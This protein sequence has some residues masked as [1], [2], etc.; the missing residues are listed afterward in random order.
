MFIKVHL[1]PVPLVECFGHHTSSG[2]PPVI[3]PP[4][5]LSSPLP[6]RGPHLFHVFLCVISYLVLVQLIDRVRAQTR[7]VA[8][9][10]I[11]LPDGEALSGVFQAFAEEVWFLN[12]LDHPNII[13]LY[14]FVVGRHSTS[15]SSSSIILLIS[16]VRL[17][18]EILHFLPVQQIYNHPRL[19]LPPPSGSKHLWS[20]GTTVSFIT[21][22][23]TSNKEFFFINWFLESKILGI[24][25][26]IMYIGDLYS[27]YNNP[28]N[29]MGWPDRL[30]IA[31]DIARY[32]FLSHPLSPKPPWCSPAATSTAGISNLPLLP[33]LCLE[34]ARTVVL[35]FALLIFLL[36]QS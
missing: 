1:P 22:A 6:S 23:K 34:S 29:V 28:A 33:S 30:E 36:L 27:Y 5:R 32:T 7:I 12:M 21:I 25:A 24:A 26:E 15:T 11:R 17:S 16:V 4:P 35:A 19:F 13:H 10:D 20:F 14:G 3:P 9:K 31:A 2:S 8:L 18:A